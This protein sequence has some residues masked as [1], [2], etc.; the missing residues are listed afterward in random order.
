MGLDFIFVTYDQ[1]CFKFVCPDGIICLML[2]E[3]ENTAQDSEKLT[4]FKDLHEIY[5][6]ACG[7]SV[8]VKPLPADVAPS[9]DS[10]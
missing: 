2:L 8:T 10:V 9:G 3:G 7:T 4:G 1:P 6:R 5:L